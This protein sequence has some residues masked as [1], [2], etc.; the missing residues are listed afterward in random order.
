MTSPDGRGDGRGGHDGQDSGAKANRRLATHSRRL[1]ALPSLPVSRSLPRACAPFMAFVQALRANGF[2]IAPEQATSFLAAVALVGP[3]SM[4]HIR[5]AGI[6]TLAPPPERRGVFDAL[7]RAIFF[8]DASLSAIGDDEDEETRIRDAGDKDERREI[9]LKQEKGGAIFS[10]TEQ[11]SVRSFATGGDAALSGFR[12]S[13]ARALPV[14]RTFRHLK[15][16]SGGSID[17]RRSMREIVRGDGDVPS[18]DF[19]RRQSV[20]RRLVLLIDVSGSMKQHTENYLRV[21]H[22]AVQATGTAEVFTIGTRLTRITR[23]LRIRDRDRALAL[24]AAAVADWDGGTRIGPALLAFLSVPRFAALSRGASVVLLS[25]GLERGDHAALETAMRRLSARAFRLSLASPLAGDARFRPETA[26]LAAILP[27]LDDLVD[28]SSISALTDFIL[29]LGRP[30][31]RAEA[32]WGRKK[33]DRH[34]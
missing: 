7:F 4:E 12:R 24:A 16:T 25:D 15:A 2:A 30:V 28:G 23:T 9:P 11:L 1:L 10:A 34:R 19:R 3:K 32:I 6:A 21:A 29:S 5:Q 14:R 27:F 20:P 26:A 13:L 8:G 33:H 22:A 31:P 17:L 18:P